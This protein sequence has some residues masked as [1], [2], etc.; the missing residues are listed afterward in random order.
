MTVKLSTIISPS[1]YKIFKQ[2]KK[3]KYTHYW[4]KGGRG[5][6][7]SSFISIC[8]VYNLMT[9]PGTHACCFRK[10][11]NTI[12]TSVFAQ[13]LW[14][15]DALGCEMF[16]KIRKSPFRIEYV[17]TGQC[18]YFFGVD[19]P[20]KIKSFKTTFGYIKQAWFEELDEFDNMEEI[21]KV[22]QSLIRG[23]DDFIIYYSYNPPKVLGNWVNQESLIKRD[24]RL[25]HHSTFLDVP[26][27]WLGKQFLQEA[28]IL[29]NTN[30]LAYNHEYLGKI[31]GTGG[32]VFENVIERVITDEEISR[33]DRIKC[34]IDWGYAVDPFVFGVMHYDKTRRTL[35]IFDE[36]YK[37][38]LLNNRAIELV[39]EKL[40]ED[41]L[42]QTIIC[43][44]AEPKSIEEF[45]RAGLRAYG[46]DKG[47]DSVRFGIKFLQDL[48]A[49]II[50]KNRCPNAFYEFTNYELEKFKDGT[51][52]D[53][54]PDK[55]NHWIDTARYGLEKDMCNKTSILDVV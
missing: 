37:R 24:D 45:R 27:N 15:I 49:I 42:G 13:I 46:A 8:I 2:I 38:G 31:T 11:G 10:V 32:L 17:P 25:I 12:E 47:R 43:D 40:G 9:Q 48:Q 28:K 14:A 35:Y 4:L 19:D 55:N 52:K 39:K 5:S 20:L 30:E 26:D 7:K 36:I 6:T 21:R 18:I 50:D 44:S 23:G 53:E 29:R 41:N 54:Y 51:W 22:T 33:F 34:G 16:F 1:F 3:G